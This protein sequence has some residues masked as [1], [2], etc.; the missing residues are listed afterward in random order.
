MRTKPRSVG[1]FKNRPLGFKIYT[2][3]AVAS[4]MSLFGV[5]IAGA[6]AQQRLWEKVQEQAKEELDILAQA[7]KFTEEPIQNLPINFDDPAT[8]VVNSRAVI[9]DSNLGQYPLGETLNP[10]DLVTRAIATNRVITATEILD[11]NNLVRYR[12]TPIRQRNQAITGAAL[13]IEQVNLTSPLVELSNDLPRFT[14]ITKVT[15]LDKTTQEAN[16][17][18]PITIA[19]NGLI[20]SYVQDFN[21]QGQSYLVAAMPILN[22]EG[23]AIAAFINGTKYAPVS[24]VLP[25]IGVGMVAILIGNILALA[26]ITKA[27]RALTSLQI[28]LRDFQTAKNPQ[29]IVVASQ[30]EIGALAAAFNT[31]IN[32]IQ[33]IEADRATAKALI[34]EQTLELEDEVGQLLDVVSDLESGN[35][36]VQAQVTDQATGLVADTLNRLIEQLANIMS[37]VLSTAQ[38]VTQGADSLEQLATAV[39][40][41]TQLQSESVAQATAEIENINLLATNASQEAIAANVAVQLAQKA[42][43]QGQEEISKLNNSIA[44]LQQGTTQIVQRLR[45]L[46]EFVDLAKQFVLDQKRLSSLTQVV[47]MNASMIAARAVE[48]KEPDQFASVAR[49]F[50]AIASQVNNLAT[51]TSQGLVVLQQRTGFIEIVVSGISQDINEVNEYVTE[52][53][54]GVEQSSQAFSDIKNVTAQV[55]ALGETVLASSQEIVQA[56]KVSAESILE[57]S[58]LAQRSASQSTLTLERSA[59]MGQLARRLLNDVRFFQLPADKIPQNYLANSK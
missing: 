45:T 21:I 8:V 41:N 2:A 57:I 20:G 44:L 3:L 19:K 54:S 26:I 47:A 49:E 38:Q 33:A 10:N 14:A 36:T 31:M 55:A 16:L 1:I 39:T 22:S 6:I 32:R 27:L 51:Q 53:T 37:T 48:Q 13:Q 23:Q 5:A 46:G 9:T 29:E 12:V 18:F 17:R 28:A 34:Q 30:D 4:F 52:F 58:A 25:I 42:V 40:Q 59:Q 56:V 7:Y 11:D 35:L 15:E 43:Y 50:E 24:I